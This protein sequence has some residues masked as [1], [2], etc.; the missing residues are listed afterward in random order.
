MYLIDTNVV[1]ET[2]RRRP[3]PSVLAWLR[4]TRSGELRV[5][6]VTIG[7]IQKGV[8]NLRDRDPVRASS[9]ESWLDDAVL[10]AFEV[11]SFDGA[12]AREWARLMRGQSPDLTIDAMIASTAV[13]HGLTVVTRNERDFDQLAVPTLNPFEF[14]G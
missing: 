2:R 11:L 13:V 5:S 10:E 12:A 3:H 7:E 9:I 4:S 14:I 8:E 6:A 1:S